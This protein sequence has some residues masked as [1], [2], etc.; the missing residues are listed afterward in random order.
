[1]GNFNRGLHEEHLLE[2]ILHQ[3]L[4]YK[5]FLFLVL[6]AILFGKVE[7]FWQF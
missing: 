3:E 4:L 5:I 6:E 7:L 2:I 1:M